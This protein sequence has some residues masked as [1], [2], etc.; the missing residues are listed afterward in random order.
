MKKEIYLSFIIYFLCFNI[1]GCGYTTRALIS[2][3]FK[4]IYINHF[5]NK[6]DITKETDAATKYKLYRPNL[7]NEITQLVINRYLIDGNLRPQKNEWADLELKGQLI[8]FRRDPLRYLDND[9]VEE[10]R[11]SI[12][13][14]IELWDK[15]QNQIIWKENNFRGEAT[16]FTVGPSAK[17]ESTAIEEAIQDLARRIVERTVEQW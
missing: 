11:I 7:E 16:Y 17:P 9:E 12:A 13:V 5:V 15:K 4:T 1:L 10:Y 2:Q 6:I 3:N 14:N 8:E